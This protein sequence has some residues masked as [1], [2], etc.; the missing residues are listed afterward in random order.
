MYLFKKQQ[1]MYW[2]I[3]INLKP[4]FKFSRF[5]DASSLKYDPGCSPRIRTLIFYP[6]PESRV[7][8]GTGSTTQQQES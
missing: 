2:V 3:S 7:Q 5:K 1:I 8:K 4:Q 6:D